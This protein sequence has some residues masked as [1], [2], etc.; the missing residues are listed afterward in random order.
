MLHELTLGLKTKTSMS[1]QRK[2]TDHCV[3]CAYI[4]FFQ[5]RLSSLSENE[6]K[7]VL[8][9]I[10]TEKMGCSFRNHKKY[11]FHM[12]YLYKTPE[13][14][15][16]MLLALCSSITSVTYTGLQLIHHFINCLSRIHTLPF[17]LTHQLINKNIHTYSNLYATIFLN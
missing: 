12:D 16:I 9:C 7:K 1:V 3:K 17:C 4:I 14:V 8:N 2:N 6:I 13:T 15:D 11:S 10:Y 5:K